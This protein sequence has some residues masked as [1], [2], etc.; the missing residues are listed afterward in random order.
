MESSL[1][2]EHKHY[3]TIEKR[4]K[5]NIAEGNQFLFD[6]VQFDK[7]LSSLETKYGFPYDVSV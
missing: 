1:R 5:K 4:F 3:G 6:R 2:P 7:E